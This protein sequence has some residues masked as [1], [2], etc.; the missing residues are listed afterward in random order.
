MLSP[1]A[2]TGSPNGNEISA[3]HSL[4]GSSLIRIF[5]LAAYRLLTTA[6]HLFPFTFP[7]L[8]PIKRGRILPNPEAVTGLGGRGGWGASPV[9]PRVHTREARWCERSSYGAFS[10]EY[11]NLPQTAF[12]MRCRS[13]R[14]SSV[15]GM[16]SV[17]SSIVLPPTVGNSVRGL[18]TVSRAFHFQYSA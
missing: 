15:R 17:R 10:F 5:C 16:Q 6:Y 12:C 8:L 1:P 7:L 13:R 9:A 11:P 18:R 14:P 4:A 3:H 2:A